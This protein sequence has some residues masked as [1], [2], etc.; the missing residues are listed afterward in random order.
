MTEKFNLSTKA[1]LAL[2]I[3]ENWESRDTVFNFEKI[4]G[5]AYFH[6]PRVIDHTYLMNLEDNLKAT[7]NKQFYEIAETGDGGAYALW[8]Y[9][10]L[11]GEPPVI[12]FETDGN[13]EMVAPS[14]EAFAVMFS[15]DEYLDEFYVDFEDIYE[16]YNLEDEEEAERLFTKE[17]KQYQKRISS[18]FEVK[19]SEAYRIEMNR[20]KNFKDWYKEIIETQKHSKGKLGGNNKP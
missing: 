11:E 20:H 10:E 17:F 18:L 5:A 8:H 19:S 9:P 4:Y 3:L 12:Y 6:T 7:I 1:Q 16:Y 13:I 15:L 2:Q 14:L